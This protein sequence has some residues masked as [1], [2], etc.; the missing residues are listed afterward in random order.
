MSRGLRG[1]LLLLAITSLVLPM[2]AA[3]A[4]AGRPEG[5][6]SPPS[7]QPRMREFLPACRSAEEMNCIESIE[8]QVGDAWVAAQ[9]P[10]PYQTIESDD[11]NGNIVYGPIIYLWETPGLEHEGGRTQLNPALV[12]R[13]DINGPPYAAYQVTIQSYPHGRDLLWDPP[14]NRCVDGDPR[15]PHGTDPC[16]RAPWLADTSYRFTF[17]T[18]TLIPIFAQSTIVG[19]GTEIT[20]IPGGLRV[21]IWGRPG[22]SQW[23]LDQETSDTR[24]AFDAVTHEWAG[25]FSDARARNGELSRCQGLGIATA[26]SNGNGGQMP[27]WDARTGSLSFGT[28]GWHFAADGSVYRGEAEIFVPGPLARCMWNVDPRQTARMEIEIFTEDGQEAAGTKAISYDSSADVVKLI[29]RNFTYSQKQFVARPAPVVAKLGKKSCDSTRSMCI[30]VDKQRT[31]ARVTVARATGT[32]VMAV[33]MIGNQE[34]TTGQ[35]RAPVSQG[36]A[37]F[38]VRLSGAKAKG[39]TWVVRTGSTFIASFRIA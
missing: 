14:I 25:L 5:Q 17:R 12:E 29:A 35:V 28:S 19:M 34:S 3:P 4:A 16:W 8:Y 26:Y 33:P 2:A 32:Q 13:D 30:T 31:A 7:A 1:P 37:A 20:S 18:S 38:T 39:Q 21:S 10:I 22:A 27:E 23:S 6:T 24:D 9:G 15:E 36:R 11:G